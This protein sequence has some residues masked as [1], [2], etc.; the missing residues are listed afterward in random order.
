MP[1]DVV[2]PQVL[3]PCWPPRGTFIGEMHGNARAP[4]AKEVAVV[5]RT[6]LEESRHKGTSTNSDTSFATFGKTATSSTGSLLAPDTQCYYNTHWC[7]FQAFFPRLTA[8]QDSA[9]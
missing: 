8:L 4:G 5:D 9:G 1:Q 6:M 7:G 3:R 2:I